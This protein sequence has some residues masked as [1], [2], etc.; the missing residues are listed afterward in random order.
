M[1]L[2]VS[3][4]AAAR[5]LVPA[6]SCLLLA[7]CDYEIGKEDPFLP[8]PTPTPTPIPLSSNLSTLDSLVSPS[9]STSSDTVQS[10]RT[11]I[12]A[13]NAELLGGA[14]E[15]SVEET[16]N[17]LGALARIQS[18]PLTVAD[19]LKIAEASLAAAKEAYQQAEAAVF[20][21][22]P[23]SAQELIAQPDPLGVA[24]AGGQD[25]FARWERLVA[26]LDIREDE[27]LTADKLSS[28]VVP[29]AE[30][31]KTSE[32]L[33]AAL[34]GFAAAWRTGE[35][36][37]FRSA[38]FSSSPDLAVARIFQGLLALTGDVMPARL[39]ATDFTAEEFQHRVNA[40]ANIYFGVSSGGEAVADGS[41]GVHDL[42][43]RA[44]P[45]QALAA[46]AALQRAKVLAASIQL[47]PTDPELTRQAGLTLS[48]L[49]T[50]LIASARSLGIM[51][52][53][54]AG[55]TAAV[56]NP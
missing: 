51:V 52:I 32:E 9:V 4:L 13:Q 39:A 44:S 20:Y 5:F 6:A 55:N 56:E 46:A 40:V 50:Q 53:D 2:F 42:V 10:L 11:Q 36:K 14:T 27:P 28:L 3:G 24:T 35:S 23:D 12:V 22:D 33:A 19:E 49:T 7:A 37:N 21:V 48:D 31:K 17:V 26:S 54:A 41:V 45:A 47:S 25:L 8:T 1:K 16:A 30:L 15:A 29:F 18:A 38:Y 43:F 34:E